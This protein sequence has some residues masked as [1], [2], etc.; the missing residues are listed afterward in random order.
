MSNARNV[1]IEFANSP[2]RESF[3]FR[4][5]RAM[6]LIPLAARLCQQSVLSYQR[7]AEQLLA[8]PTDSSTIT[9][10]GGISGIN[11]DQSPCQLC[12]SLASDS[13][14]VRLIVD[15]ASHLSEPDKRYQSSLA[16]L[17]Q[18]GMDKGLLHLNQRMLDW[19]GPGKQIRAE[20]FTHGVM[21]LATDFNYTSWATYIDSSVHKPDKAWYLV[22]QWLQN[23]LPISKHTDKLIQDVEPHG[24]LSSVSIEGISE[25]HARLKIYFRLYS[26]RPQG[27][28]DGVLPLLNNSEFIKGLE[29]LMG[30][31]SLSQENLLISVGFSKQTGKVSD[32]KLDIG[33]TDFG[34]TGL[35]SWVLLKQLCFMYGFSLPDIE[36][37]LT[38]QWIR[39]SFIGLGVTEDGRI[40]C[41][42]YLKPGY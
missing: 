21:W 29:L 14:K 4:L 22:K 36:N 18:I 25:I 31:N 23:S 16:T 41:N 1:T 3:N 12:L 38:T 11:H 39:L 7:L 15:P 40:K 6:R 33:V 34:L 26:N 32:T 30:D 24:W 17:Q 9:G 37:D 2:N 20:S 10:V 19:F 35:E 42:L 27:A 28:L 13:S 5:H 8:L